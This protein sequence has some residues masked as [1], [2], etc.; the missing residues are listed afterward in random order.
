MEKKSNVYVRAR[1]VVRELRPL[2]ESVRARD[3]K[4]ADQLRR[5]AQSVVLN[6]AE[7]R[8]SKAG[9]ARVRFMNACGSAK[10]VRAA[11]DVAG[12]WGY[13]DARRAHL[14]D[15]ELDQICAITWVLSR[16]G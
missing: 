3:A 12:D 10:E 14:I 4:L 7:G 8:G 11:L 9:L 5:A 2:V 13:I 1:K 6:I 15:A 16:K